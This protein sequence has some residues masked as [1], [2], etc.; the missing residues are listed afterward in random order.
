MSEEDFFLEDRLTKIRSIIEKYGE[1]NFYISYSGGMDSVCLSELTDMAL[2]GNMIP[3]VHASTGLEFSLMTKFVMKKARE[4]VR[5]HII[6]PSVQIIP[7]LKRDG[8]PFKS[9]NH[10]RLVDRYQRR[11]KL[12]SVESYLGN[13]EW[14][15]TLQ[16]P[17]ILKYQFKEENPELRISDMCCVNMKEKPLTDWAVENG[18][19][20]AMIGVMKSEGGRRQ[21]AKCLNF[22][23]GVLK[24]FQ[25]L[26]VATKEWEWWFIKKYNIELCELYYPPFSVPRS[27][28]LGCPFNRELKKELSMMEKYPESFPGERKKAELVFGPVYDVYRRL[29]YRLTA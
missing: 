11:G 27:G 2:P 9:K 5:L 14:G 26:S 12:P 20:Y 22:K 29:N 16:C 19:R 21:S 3:R 10:A 7:S 28:C 6:K 15:P 13:G 24:S 4:D 8:Y 23:D 17:K 18:K 1:E 25:P